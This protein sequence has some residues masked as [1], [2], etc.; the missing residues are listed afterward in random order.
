MSRTPST[1][2]DFRSLFLQLS[3]LV[4]EL[5]MGKRAKIRAK[6][7]DYS[8]DLKHQLGLVAGANALLERYNFS[9]DI[10]SEI[11]ELAAVIREAVRQ[12]D[13]HIDALTENLN[14]QIDSQD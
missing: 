3:A 1:Q 4:N 13:G 6:L 5:P 14:H 11:R 7:G 8:H 2:E 10:D 9:E 12:I